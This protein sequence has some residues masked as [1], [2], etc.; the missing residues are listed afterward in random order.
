MLKQS[1]ASLLFL[2]L[3]NYTIEFGHVMMLQQKY[4]SR[5]IEF[6]EVQHRNIYSSIL[7]AAFESK[8]ASLVW[9]LK[10]EENLKLFLV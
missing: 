10:T 7:K 8:Y 4:P 6:H 1:N 2:A 5:R 9:P 3:S